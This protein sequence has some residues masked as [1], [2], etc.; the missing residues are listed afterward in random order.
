MGSQNDKG[1]DCFTLTMPQGAK[2]T[3][4]LFAF[5]IC[6]L[7]LVQGCNESK[8]QQKEDG[9]Q[10]LSDLPAN[11]MPQKNHVNADSLL[12][13]IPGKGGM[14]QPENILANMPDPVDFM[15]VNELTPGISNLQQSVKEKLAGNLPVKSKKPEIVAINR[16]KQK[17]QN[18]I[19]YQPPIVTTVPQAM[20]LSHSNLSTYGKAAVESGLI[21]IQHN[22]SIFPPIGLPVAN[23]LQIKALP[24]KYKESALFDICLLDADQELPDS[25]I[26][27]IAKDNNGIIWFGTHTG[28]LVSYDGQFFNQYTMGSGL[29]SN[30][31][32]SLLINKNN[33][34]WIGTQDGGA[35]FF[36]GKRIIRYTEKQGLPSNSILAILEDKN[37]NIWFATKKGV[38]MFDGKTISTFTTHQG[39]G[40]DAVTS[41]LE[42]DRGNIWFGTVGGVTRYCPDTLNNWGNGKGFA[43]F[44]KKDGLAS[45]TVLSI[46]QDHHGNIWFGTNGGGV[47]KFDGRTFTNYSTA[48][49]LGSDVILSMTEGPDDNMWFGTFGNGITRFNGNSFSRFTTN[50]GLGDD[51]VRTLFDDGVG[52]LW[53][54]TDGG[55][56]SVFNIH[57]FTHFTTE[58]GL[59]NNL[60]LSVFQDDRNR[61]WFGTFDGGILI[62]DESEHPGQKSTF[63]NITAVQGLANNIVTSIVQDDQNNF[64]FGTY[65]GGVSKLDGKSIETGELEF[66]NYSVEQGLNNNSVRYVLQDNK[67]NMWFA[68][69]RG[70]TKFDGNEFVTLTKKAGLGSNKVLCIFQE[71]GG[72][73]WFGTMDGGV[74]RFENDTLIRYTTN[75]GLGNN[76]VWAIA[77]DNNGIIWFGTNG[78]GLTCYDGHSFRTYD[79]E[80][81]LCNDYV[82]S[83]VADNNNSIWAGTVRGLAQIKVSDSLPVGKESFLD[84]EPVMMNYG[85][86]D[87]LKSM[88]FFTNAVFHDNSNRLWWGTGKALS[89]L[90]LN[91]FKPP[92]NAPNVHF[93]GLSINGKTINFN[94]L[95]ANGNG[96]SLTVIR[97]SDVLPFSNNPTGLI[98]PHDRNH[99][100]FRFSASDWRAPDQI[101]YQYKLLGFDRDWGLLTKDNM[102]DYRNI[103][104]GKYSFLLRAIGKAGIWSN[105]LEYPFVVR[106]PLL[107]TWWAIL[108]YMIAFGFLIWLFIGWRV[109]IVKKQKIVLENLIFDRTKELDDARI[110]AEQATLAKSQFIATI[111]HEIR[112]PLNAIM[113]LTHLAIVTDLNPKQEDYL[114]KIDRSAITLR[115]LINDILDFSKMEAGKMQLENVDFDLEIVMNSII[116]FNAQHA[117][118][119]NLEFVVNINPLVPRLLIGDPLRIGQVITNLCSNAIKFT[120]SGEITIN[121]D[122]GKKTT[123]GK[124]YLQVAVRDTGIGIDKGQI[125][126]LFDEFKQADSSTTRKYGGTGLGLTISKLL[127]E[128]MGGH[129][130][131]ESEP[132]KG[133]TFFF[134]CK[135]GVR[136]GKSSPAHT[137][138]DELKEF[139]IL[140]CDDNPSALKSLVATLRSFS[141][142]VDAATSG[143]DVLK[144][145]EDKPYELLLIDQQLSGI[146]GIDT[147]LSI[148]GNPD[149]PPIKTILVTDAERSKK[150]FEQDALGIDGYLGKPSVPSVVLEKILA[151]F[152]ME[153][154]S[155]PVHNKKEAHLKQVENAISGRRILLTED[156]EINRQVIFELLEKVCVQV[157]LADNGTIALQKALKNSYDLILMDLH[158]PVMDG[159]DASAQIREHNVQVPII[160]I[161]ADAMDTIKAKC[162]EAGINDIVTKPIDPDLLYDKLV[163]WVCPDLKISRDSHKS[164]GDIDVNM[165]GISIPNLDMQSAIRRFGDNENLY[166]KML[167]K[168]ISTNQQTCSVL[169]ELV[170]EGDFEQA[171]LT[172]HTLKGESGNIGAVKVHGLSKQVEQAILNKDVPGFDKEAI[173]LENSMEEITLAVQNHFRET[174]QDAE[175]D[176]RS[177]KEL[178]K[179]LTVCLKQKNPKAFDLLDELAAKGI[180]KSDLDAVDKAVNN[181]D[182]D[183]A[184]ALLEKLYDSYGISAT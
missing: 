180:K 32:I 42:D 20:N 125:P 64:W 38:S 151:V 178:I 61:M 164:T 159:Y 7:F 112:T 59:N 144:Q 26:R 109:N 1:K 123:D 184:F 34:L 160:A 41:L 39:L 82:F 6:I 19:Q 83:L 71:K 153:K 171:H 149:I 136:P 162:D 118:T 124:L 134:D 163:K 13:R 96:H 122:A 40:N 155:S 174:G 147:I 126:L 176:A 113:G 45:D 65:G 182:L 55:G 68:T 99:L 145:L 4:K 78:G 132:G 57:G 135:V 172:V 9:I 89:M 148:Q 130:W 90:D 53:I 179:E 142:K 54:G 22:D 29:S 137:I 111:S 104:P 73:L 116:V 117:H 165:P 120:P 161:T 92:E 157:D 127:I 133:S 33:N 17:K 121:I 23:P 16:S 154:T 146:S 8:I 128:M 115:S 84:I 181:H 85:K 97:F 31:V 101:Q 141:L 106:R 108:T 36:D 74:S 102:A 44:T 87:G 60:V 47:S 158:M 107:L 49:G 52:N 93:N 48:Q 129:I 95:K 35:N 15:G 167:G 170:R 30:M 2:S 62:F 70:V 63:T 131:L 183:G 76:T 28:G 91:T 138:P 10:H 56:A 46:A 166:M 173:L 140:V 114:Q 72:G 143:E 37:G 150:N 156:N 50:E 21:T 98:L 119:K 177:I 100:T 3:N 58:Q 25:F 77:Q 139:D 80:D 27:A 105:I 66:T 169:R 86:K 51:Y 88:D 67:G 94:E 175:T 14:K 152:G 24:M 79:S 110:L 43:T 12:I 69:E 103:P 75:Q 11:R 5:L 168:F 81:G 18:S